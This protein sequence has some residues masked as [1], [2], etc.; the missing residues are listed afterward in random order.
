MDRTEMIK[1]I[2][3]MSTF[4]DASVNS[5]AIDAIR[6]PE[7]K[8]KMDHAQSVLLRAEERDGVCREIIAIVAYY[9]PDIETQT[10]E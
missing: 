7:D 2:Q 9:W 5:A 6:N 3:D 10:I 1:K 4:W 8:E